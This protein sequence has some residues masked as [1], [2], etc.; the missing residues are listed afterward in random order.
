MG[1]SIQI[2]K[3]PVH[4]NLFILLQEIEK[5]A[6]RILK[7]RPP[8][9][10]SV[11]AALENHTARMEWVMRA[12]GWNREFTLLCLLIRTTDLPEQEMPRLVEVLK[13]VPHC[14]SIV[15][16][17]GEAVINSTIAALQSAD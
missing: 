17:S 16:K 8:E 12:A 13:K 10:A 14:R 9:G 2:I 7:S 1:S 6:E 11:V 4:E 3:R 15:G 5:N